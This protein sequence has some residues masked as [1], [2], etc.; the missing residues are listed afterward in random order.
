MMAVS[1]VCFVAYLA[2]AGITAGYELCAQTDGLDFSDLDSGDFF[3]SVVFGMFWPIT[4]PM[5]LCYSWFR[6]TKGG[7]K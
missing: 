4:L 3:D 5:L 6:G 7:K 2:V 1:L